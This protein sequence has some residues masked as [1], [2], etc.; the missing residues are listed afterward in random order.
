MGRARRAPT[1]DLGWRRGKACPEV[2]ACGQRAQEHGFAGVNGE[3]A[4]VGE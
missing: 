1:L 3:A 4:V 2:M